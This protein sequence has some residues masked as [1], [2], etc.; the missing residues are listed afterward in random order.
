MYVSTYV[1]AD[2]CVFINSS[3]SWLS[4]MASYRNVLQEFALSKMFRVHRETTWLNT[5][6]CESNKIASILLIH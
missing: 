6:R 5:Y 2:I 3:H 4:R 1:H